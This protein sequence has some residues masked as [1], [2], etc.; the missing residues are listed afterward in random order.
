MLAQLPL[1]ISRIFINPT[2][3][4]CFVILPKSYYF[5][6]GLAIHILIRLPP[7]TSLKACSAPS[8]LN[9]LIIN[10]LTSII[11]LIINLRGWEKRKRMRGMTGGQMAYFGQSRQGHRRFWLPQYLTGIYIATPAT[12]SLLLYGDG[13]YNVFFYHEAYSVQELAPPWR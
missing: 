6:F 2:P 10:L 13:L 8:N 9:V 1:A 5:P 12:G 11:V 3:Q 4:T 7:F